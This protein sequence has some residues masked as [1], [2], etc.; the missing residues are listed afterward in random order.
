MKNI[1]LAFDGFNFSNSTFEF[2][3]KLNQIQRVLVTGVFVPQMDYSSSWGL[4]AAVAGAY[5]PYLE[6]EEINAIEE[7]VARFEGL[8]KKN[9]INYRIHKDL[10]EFTLP[11]LKKE[12]RFADAMIISGDL[13]HKRFIETEQFDYVRDLLHTAECPVLVLPEDYHFPDQNILAYD[14]SE[15]SVYAI[16]QFAYVFPGL[17]G[18][19]SFLVYAENDNSDFPSKKNIVELANQHYH[20]LE[21][22][23][24]ETDPKKFF[25]TWVKNERGCILITGSFSRSAISEIFRKSFASEIIRDHTIPVF[26][27][28]K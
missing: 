3:R 24:L 5:V 23:R 18:N 11:E 12:S 1:L 15:E 16:K 7:N 9:N 26:I 17:T 8:C 25:S 14:G 4:S 21:L 10:Y 2:V 28:H 22:Y 20:D 27:A 19:K 6:D 13:F